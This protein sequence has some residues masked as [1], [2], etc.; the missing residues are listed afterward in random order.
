[1]IEETLNH[2][3]YDA[4]SSWDECPV[5]APSEETRPA[6][7]WFPKGCVITADLITIAVALL[8]S[9]RLR[10]VLPGVETGNYAEGRHM[11]LALI[12]LPIWLALF[13][14]YGLYLGRKVSSRVEEFGAI[15]H[16]VAGSVLAMI[17]LA[18]VLKLDVSRGW[19]VATLFV[20][21]GLVTGEREVVR[22]VFGALRRRGHL[23]RKVIIVGNNS[24]ALGLCSL[25]SS[26]PAL[27]Y[28]VVG[29][30]G[31][32]HLPH[33]AST[34]EWPILGRVD[35]T[36]E[37]VR[38]TGATG[39]LL[40]TSAMDISVA[41]RLVR[42]LS[43]SGIH[44]EMSSPL[45]DISAARLT[46]QPLGDSP[47]V[48]VEPIRL[49]GW[50]AAAKRGFD[51]VVASVGLVVTLPI[52]A[53]AAIAIRVRTGSPILFRQV[54][55]G[56]GG[57]PFCMLK[58]RTMVCGAEDMMATVGDHNQAGF[59]LFKLHDDPRVSSV[60]RFL[61][62]FSI[63]EVPQ[64]WNVLRGQMSVVGPRPALPQ[65]MGSW[66]AEVHKRLQLKPGMTGMWQVRGRC[67]NSF[68]EYTRWDLY[69][70]DNW[71]LWTDVAI[72]A[73]TIPAVLSRRGAY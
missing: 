18:F 61:R 63:D 46:V 59:P 35:Q 53:A 38:R 73:R 40:A 20:T 57:Q 48:Y 36:A 4:V 21:V 72:V 65:E 34:G 43:T 23:L 10:S 30:V 37:V 52:M 70:L 14:K 11:L 60:G 22:Q 71:S 54:R 28:R 19:L 32:E 69:Y 17:V 50:R 33:L 49:T 64:F 3:S 44:V 9:Y 47:V 39:V 62:R 16:A 6:R 8:L 2:A 58:L 25:L 55:V 42:D 56:R 7:S 45:V 41:N 1:M 24:E 12:A 51:I 27:G 31:E 5:E 29:L 15:T 13:F 67:D 68:A 26:E 66:S